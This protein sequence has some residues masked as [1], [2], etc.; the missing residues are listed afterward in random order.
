MEILTE[1]INRYKKGDLEALSDIISQMTPLLKKYARK[2]YCMEYEDA[3]Q[4]LYLSLI[5]C[6][7]YLSKEKGEM[8]CLKYINITV[9]H[10]YYSLCK[11]Y[12]SQ[13]V[14]DIGD[15]N[16]DNLEDSYNTYND[17]LFNT[18]LFNYI[19]EIHNKNNLKGRIIYLSYI[20]N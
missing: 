1:N 9:K 10:K 4:E 3:L 6:I 16:L 17:I 13:P 15:F 8:K 14:Q 11:K 2:L 5:Q 12:L 19:I 18:A 7:P 20:K